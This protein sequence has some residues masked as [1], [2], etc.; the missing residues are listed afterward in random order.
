MKAS[1]SVISVLVLMLMLS[2]LVLPVSADVIYEPMCD[3]YEAHRDEC[4]YRDYRQYVVNT[5]VGHAYSYVDPEVKTG[6]V[7]VRNGEVL[8]IEWVYRDKSGTEWGAYFF[9]G[10]YDEIQWILMSDLTVVYDRYSFMEEHKDEIKDYEKWGEIQ[11]YDVSDGRK[12]TAWQYPGGGRTT[13]LHGSDGKV[14]FRVEKTYTD[15]EGNEWGSI[16]VFGFQGKIGWVCLSDLYGENVKPMP[17]TD[18]ERPESASIVTVNGTDISLKAEPTPAD[19][20]KI[21][22]V[23]EKT[24]ETVGALVGGVMLVTAL[25]I[26]VIFGRKKPT[27]EEADK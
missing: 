1:R 11:E 6:T 20:I 3:F 5:D 24:L 17:D 2:A 26:G 7:G 19:E 23:S 27:S 10:S 14:Y 12:I 8:A 13:E 4:E 18:E 15:E 22:G 16:S 21:D 25:A 9:E